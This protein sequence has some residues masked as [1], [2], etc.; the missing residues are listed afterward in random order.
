MNALSQVRQEAERLPYPIEEGPNGGILF[1]VTYS[2]QQHKFTPEQIA[3]MLFTK[4]RDTAEAA[5][6]TKCKDVVISVPCYYAD[7]ERRALLD[8]AAMAGLKQS[9]AEVMAMAWRGFM[10]G[11]TECLYLIQARS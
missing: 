3:A 9:T 5:L 4:L 6:G 11:R 8:A 7:C 2:G 1:T 10:G